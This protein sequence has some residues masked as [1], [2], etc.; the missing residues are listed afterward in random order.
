MKRRAFNTLSVLSLLLCVATSLLWVR[1]CWIGDVIVVSDS[2]RYWH[3]LISWRGAIAFGWRYS[4]GIYP[5]DV[6]PATFPSQPE[7]PIRQPSRWFVQ[8]RSY[9]ISSQSGTLYINLARKWQFAGFG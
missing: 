5:S 4:D 1:S 7:P 2:S 9:Q 6:L 3:T 8:H